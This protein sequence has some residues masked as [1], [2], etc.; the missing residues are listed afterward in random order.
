MT[1]EVRSRSRPVA[2]RDLWQQQQTWWGRDCDRD[3]DCDSEVFLLQYS[4][5]DCRLQLSQSEKL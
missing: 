2:R 5:T 1:A 3:Y 4:T